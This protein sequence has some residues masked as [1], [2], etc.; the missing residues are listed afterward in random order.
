VAFELEG[1]AD[2]GVVKGVLGAGAAPGWRW[3]GTV[4]RSGEVGFSLDGYY[5][6]LHGDER[7]GFFSVGANLTVPLPATIRFG[8]GTCTG[9]GLCA[10]GRRQRAPAGRQYQG[11]HFG[12]V[13]FSY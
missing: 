8:A 1:Q 13:G 4:S 7:F 9:S 12:G 3:P 11:H 5:E 10:A 2:G 6:G